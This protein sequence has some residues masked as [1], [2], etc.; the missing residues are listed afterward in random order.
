MEKFAGSR[1]YRLP[2]AFWVSLIFLGLASAWRLFIAVDKALMLIAYIDFFLVTAAF[3]IA[4][5]Q[6]NK[7]RNVIVSGALLLLVVLTQIVNRGYSVN[8]GGIFLS[9]SG[10]LA[11]RHFCDLAYYIAILVGAVFLFLG[12]ERNAAICGIVALP[13]S[14]GY[15]ITTA[16]L[17]VQY[18]GDFVV[19]WSWW[20]QNEMIVPMYF[21]LTFFVALTLVF[22]KYYDLTAPMRRRRREQLAQENKSARKRSA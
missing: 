18:T 19:A 5:M 22:F 15:T 7:W 10:L 21:V 14:V 1:D 20:L 3:V 9:G 11:L 12:K 6:K 13:L 2:V 17:T 16:V 4:A 8:I